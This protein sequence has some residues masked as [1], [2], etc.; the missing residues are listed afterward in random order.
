MINEHWVNGPGERLYYEHLMPDV[1]SQRRLSVAW[2]R[3]MSLV[4]SIF[5]I[6]V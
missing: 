6:P 4:V 1:C 5:T 2:R 3:L